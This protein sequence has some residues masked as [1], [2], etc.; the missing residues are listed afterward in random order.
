MI[1]NKDGVDMC[2]NDLKLGEKAF[3]SGVVGD[4]KL[5]KR[6]S[7]LGCTEGCLIE[8]V[9][10]APFGDPIVLSLRGTNLAIRKKDAKNISV[11]AR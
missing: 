1:F 4:K 5:V 10:K 6:L 7:A 9:N 8:V 3:V 11:E 2:I